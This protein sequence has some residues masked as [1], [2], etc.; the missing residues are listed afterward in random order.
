[1]SETTTVLGKFL[2]AVVTT[3]LVSDDMVAIEG[4][5]FVLRVAK[6]GLVHTANRKIAEVFADRKTYAIHREPKL[7]R[8]HL[9]A[10]AYLR[11]EKEVYYAY[12][13]TDVYE[14]EAAQDVA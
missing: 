10:D 1:M 4:E 12:M 2:D 3:A 14:G 6:D 5:E 13:K 11:G 9:Y 8:G 7:K